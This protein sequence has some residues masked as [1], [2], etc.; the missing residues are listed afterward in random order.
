M[1]T[2]KRS[3]SLRARSASRSARFTF[4]GLV[5]SAGV[6][7]VGSGSVGAVGSWG[8]GALV[9]FVRKCRKLKSGI[10]TLVQQLN[11]VPQLVSTRMIISLSHHFSLILSSSLSPMCS[12]FS[13]SLV[14]RLALLSQVYS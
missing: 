6:G 3:P 4:M 8:F 10:L 7:L 12:T 5:V 1:V 9:I 2:L 14:A 11:L 13:P